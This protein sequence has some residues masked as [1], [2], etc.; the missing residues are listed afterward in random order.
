[1]NK[2]VVNIC[3]C[4]IL[5]LAAFSISIPAKTTKDT[6]LK[7]GEIIVDD[8]GDGDFTS[9]QE[10]I[11]FA[12]PGDIIKVYSGTYDDI[13]Y[14]D[15]IIIDKTLTLEGISEEYEQGSDTGKPVIDGYNGAILTII[16]TDLVEVSG[17]KIGCLKV[18]RSSNVTL[19]YN[20]LNSRRDHGGEEGLSIYDSKDISIFKNSFRNHLH[21]LT[22]DVRSNSHI[23]VYQ[24]NFINNI[25]HSKFRVTGWYDSGTKANETILYNGNYWGADLS[26]WEED[27]IESWN[28]F[29]IQNVLFYYIFCKRIDYTTFS[30]TKKFIFGKVL[31]FK[32][33]STIDFAFHTFFFDENPASEPIDF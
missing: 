11:D 26:I 15:S 19:S 24:N 22:I 23:E 12:Q 2:K 3:I 10:A 30:L 31:P 9:I 7:K 20:L 21:A 17:F 33:E 14:P 29:I 32:E 5:I 6:N 18:I 16:D 8:E 1:M 4:I 25:R 28:R 13:L 27:H